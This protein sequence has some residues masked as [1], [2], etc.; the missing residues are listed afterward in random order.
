MYGM[1]RV[2]RKASLSTV[3]EIREFIRPT[4]A[5]REFVDDL[6]LPLAEIMEEFENGS[7][8]VA[9]RKIEIDEIIGWL[10]QLMAIS[11]VGHSDWVPVA[12]ECVRRFARSSG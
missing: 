12:L 8:A 7:I 6:L 2:R 5:P 10:K 1:I 4:K 9:N 11:H 3:K